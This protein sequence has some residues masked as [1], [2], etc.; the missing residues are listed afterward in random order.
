MAKI[1]KSQ[2]AILYAILMIV[3]GIAFVVGGAGTASWLM[4]AIVTVIGTSHCFR[5]L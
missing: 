1:S 3:F 4:G 5:Y 2:S